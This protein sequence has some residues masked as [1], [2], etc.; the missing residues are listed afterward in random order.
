MPSRPSPRG[1]MVV[2]LARPLN[3]MCSNLIRIMLNGML[4][5][6]CQWPKSTTNGNNRKSR[7]HGQTRA[8]T[9]GELH[10]KCQRGAFACVKEQEDTGIYLWALVLGCAK[11]HRSASRSA[12]DGE[13]AVIISIGF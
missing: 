2:A 1:C 4:N 13:V 10:V 12:A 6:N 5:D 9:G 3:A 11:T 8:R 7:F